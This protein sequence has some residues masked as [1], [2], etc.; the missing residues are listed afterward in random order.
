MR[1][2]CHLHIGMNKAGSTSIQGAFHD[3][4]DDRLEYIRPADDTVLHS[5]L[6]RT[7]HRPRDVNRFGSDGPEL[8]AAS[9]TFDTLMA[10]SDRAAFISY[11][12][13]SI[14]PETE[15]IERIRD[16]LLSHCRRVHVLAYIRP[17]RAYLRSDI[18]QRVKLYPPPTDLGRLWPDY[19]RRFARWDQVFGRDAVTLVPFRRGDLIG[20][21]LLQDVCVRIGAEPEGLAPR[22]TANVAG[23]LEGSTALAVWQAA[24]AAGRMQTPKHSTA[25]MNRFALIVAEFGKTRSWGFSEAALAP[26]L[27]DRAADMDWIVERLGCSDFRVES[28][29][30]VAID[31]LDALL[32]IGQGQAPKL[33]K[34]LPGRFPGLDVT[35]AVAT[36][37]LVHAAFEH[38]LRCPP[39]PRW[40]DRVAAGLQRRLGL[41]LAQPRL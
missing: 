28:G 10:S 41:R 30:E 24:R 29:A 21:D 34:W 27:R 25:Q 38:A 4:R 40:Q 19:Q 14:W 18:Q 1:P 8:A 20:G 12:N 36:E 5:V 11:E 13:L 26:L 23:R 39:M 31:G 33:A 37:D 32:E 7:F 35:G 2:V 15:V 9:A 22:K 3:Y 17:P 16:R 6:D